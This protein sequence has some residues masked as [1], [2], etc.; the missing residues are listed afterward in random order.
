M[1]PEE[2]EKLL[3]SATER[4][5]G[6]VAPLSR[7]GGRGRTVGQGAS[8]DRTIYADKAAEDV[9]LKALSRAEVRVLSEEA[10]LVG[11]KGTATLA[12]VDPLDGSSNF[13]RGIPF[14]CT[15]VAIA[16]GDSLD[17]VAVGVVR[18]L[19]T[20]DVYS[21]VRGRGA[22]K[23]GREIGTSRE[24]EL[25]KAVVGIDLSRGGRGNAE[26]LAPLVGAVKRQI[27]LG[28][29]AL[30]LCY[31]AE[32]RSDA[33]VDVRGRIRITDLAAAYLIAAEAGAVI[34]GTDGRKLDATFDLSHRLSFVASANENLHKQ[35]LEVVGEP[36]GGGAQR[37]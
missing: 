7:K 17:S 34:T 4:V 29:N 8:G 6:R 3:L 31:M 15:S 24:T 20:G 26:R 16:E 5:R 27:H 1:K 37:G 10:G 35:I 33:F 21:A 14:Y 28:A 32:G 13:E 2:W 30:E 12:I 23:N 22:R 9:I 36:R 25:S 18:D 19:V 11:G